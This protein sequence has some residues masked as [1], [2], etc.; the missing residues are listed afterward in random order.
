MKKFWTTASGSYKIDPEALHAF[1]NERG[2]YTFKP[3]SVNSTILVKVENRHVRQVS[4]KEIREYCWRYIESEYQFQEDEERKQIKTEFHRNRSYFSKDNIDLLPE[5]EINEIKDS[6]EKSYLFFSNCILEIT[7]GSY[8]IKSYDEIEGHVFEGDIIHFDFNVEMKQSYEPEG[9]FYEFIKDICKNPDT[10]IQTANICSMRTIIG[11][12][13]HRYKDPGNAKAIIFMD[14]YKDGNPNG[15]TGKGLLTTALKY[16]R[17][18]VFQDGKIY[19][20]SDKFNLSE[21]TYGTR[22]L[23]FDDVPK[24]F[25]F[26]K[27]FPL[28]TERAVV[29]RKYVN[30]FTIPFELSPKVLITTNYTIEGKGASYNRR[31]FEFIFS[32]T[33]NEDYTPEDKFGHLLFNE[34]DIEEWERF[35]AFMAYCIESYLWL[36]LIEPEF[37]FSERKLKIEATSEFI[38]YSNEYLT[39]GIKYNKKVVYEDFYTKNPNHH[40]LALTT[41]RNWIKLFAEAYGFGFFESHSGENLFFELTT[42]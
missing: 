30:K 14:T 39:V 26:E 3:D 37:N 22:I 19:S 12:L 9:E 29:E 21:V 24:N 2:Y 31:K 18:P 27:I 41:F 5:I 38:K 13:L 32:D 34:W 42:D 6:E 11:Y 4:P 15:G 10:D 36:E 23:V 35:Y 1:L 7:E 28:I 17:K 20:T 25:D 40:R 8:I 33:F 16:I